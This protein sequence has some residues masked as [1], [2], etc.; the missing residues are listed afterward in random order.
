M[1]PRAATILACHVALER[2]IIVVLGRLLPYPDRLRNLGFIQKV[3][4]LN[5]A[6][7]GDEMAGDNVAAALGRFNDLRNT[8]GHGNDD[9]VEGCVRSLRAAY[10]NL[11][12]ECSDSVTVED[13]AGGIVAYFGDGPTPEEIR[14][15]VNGMAHIIKGFGGFIASMNKSLGKP[16][17][18]AAAA[19]EGRAA[20][21]F[22]GN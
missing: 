3:Q 1:D 15:F 9:R 17:S 19:S 20:P 4:V 12:P 16:D 10:R 21:R 14:V 22:D 18:N 7:I 8:I 11:H 13:M 5:A 6:W 2:E